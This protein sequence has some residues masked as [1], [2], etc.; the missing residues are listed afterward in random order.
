MPAQD[1]QVQQVHHSVGIEVACLRSGPAG[2]A[3]EEPPGRRRRRQGRP[4]GSPTIE[5]GEYAPSLPLAFRIAWA[6]NATV[7]DVFQ[8][9]NAETLPEPPRS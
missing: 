3:G 5:A 4:A 8:Y 1:R 7:E 9:Q 2:E 6:F